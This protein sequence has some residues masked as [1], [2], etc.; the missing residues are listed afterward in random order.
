MS[1]GEIKNFEPRLEGRNYLLKID[2]HIS[3]LSEIGIQRPPIILSGA[4]VYVYQLANGEIID[5]VPTDLDLVLQT[6]EDFQRAIDSSIYLSLYVRNQS[7]VTRWGMIYH[8]VLLE[9]EGDFPV[10]LMRYLNTLFPKNHES[11]P[12]ELYT[13]PDFYIFP[14]LTR[15]VAVNNNLYTLASPAYIV[16]YKLT[17]MRNG[18]SDNGT[19][20]QD[21]ED[22]RRLHRLGLLT[23]EN[24][25]PEF[26][27][28]CY[29]NDELRKRLLN[30]LS[31]IIGEEI[32][33]VPIE[34]KQQNFEE[35][36]NGLIQFTSILD[37][38]FGEGNWC[39][40]NGTALALHAANRGFERKITDVDIFYFGGQLEDV[41]PSNFFHIPFG[42][43]CYDP[44]PH[45][46]HG[47]NYLAPQLKGRIF[48]GEVPYGIDIIARSE[49]EKD[50]QTMIIDV[51]KARGSCI[52]LPFGDLVVPVMGLDL[53]K[54]IKA[55]SFRPEPKT[56]REDLELIELIK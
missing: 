15:Q 4:G 18:L 5:R 38:V 42:R 55:F 33:F 45:F 30:K 53:I 50:G 9:G 27:I 19:V 40:S 8:N 28:L 32:P 37:S 29:G 44:N 17:Q 52:N 6:D 10:D 20:K 22:I 13:F 21:L 39:F 2:H 34:V 51:K 26:N 35:Q 48:L 16:F 36:I 47:I 56:D 54:E 46:V 25:N 11:F 1:K 31:E 49:M 43:L 24:L 7:R 23:S 3:C 12:L 14:Q 41:F